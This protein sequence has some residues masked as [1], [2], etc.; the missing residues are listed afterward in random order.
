MT[1]A[2]LVSMRMPSLMPAMPD[3]TIGMMAG[4]FGGGQ[5]RPRLTTHHV[6]DCSSGFRI[7]G[8]T[9]DQPYFL[10]TLYKTWGFIEMIVVK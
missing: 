2:S 3:R 8:A 7:T 9:L 5:Q 1:Q 4:T 10:P 6:G